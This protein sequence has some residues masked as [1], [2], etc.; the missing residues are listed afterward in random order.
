M[1]SA[2]LCTA[3]VG[4]ALGGDE[5]VAFN[6]SEIAKI[7]RFSPLPPLPRDPTNSVADDPVAARLG[8]R[9]FF[10]TR[11]SANG[12]IACATCHDPK[13]G[14]ADGKP[15][16]EGVGT[17]TRH[18]PALWNVA[19]A[20]W[21][22]WDGR[23]DSTWS[24]ALQPIEQPHEMAGN[25]LR[26]THLV[27]EDSA[28]HA[29]YVAVFGKLPDLAD[30]QRFPRDALPASVRKDAA[31]NAAW[32]SMS[33]D[34]RESANRVFVNA[35]KAIAA[36]E[37]KI[38]SRNA[39]FDAFVEGLRS[40]DS[41]KLEAMS[42]SSQRGLRLFVGRALCA[43]CHIGPNFTDGEFHDT[44]VPSRGN[45]PARDAGRYAGVDLVKRDPFNSASRYSDD[46]RSSAAD[47]LSFLVNR[48]ENWGQ[49]KTPSLR[50]VAETAPY[51][52]KGQFATLEEVV[53]FYSTL[54]GR[55]TIGHHPETILLPLNLSDD[56][57]QDLIA[58]LRALTG[59]PLDP[60]LTEMP[61]AR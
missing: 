40:G 25:R 45:A 27:D 9:L 47:R 26:L 61:P 49:F 50:N 16:A 29:D 57:K 14:F 43:S 17:T 31:P 3:V 1:T 28:L 56:E 19:Y 39:P 7:V 20:R 8:Q 44:G 30:A 53:D 13:H 48:E 38:V 41:R 2:W 6:E 51:M 34:D 10:D 15:L 54:E 58:F 42:A 23:A 35:A 52:H 4:L 22:F 59:E 21:L 37:R 33:P 18:A 32:D 36:F 55:V 24:Q 46:A 11:F 12:R 5:R 60:R